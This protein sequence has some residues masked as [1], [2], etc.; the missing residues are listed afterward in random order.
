MRECG[1]SGW[2]YRTDFIR[3]RWRRWKRSLSKWRKG[4]QYGAPRVKMIS[5]V[6]GKEVGRGEITAEY[7]RRQVREAVRYEK[8]ME[9]LRET[10]QRVFVEVGPGSTLIGLGRQCMEGQEETGKAERVWAVS[11]RKNKQEWEQV[12]ESLGKLYERGAEVDWEGFDRGIRT[13]PRGA[14]HLPVPAPALLD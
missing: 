7:W 11:I 14:A 6:T 4:L 2:R 3:R 5:S 12:L 9:T 10:G 13:A 8:A 1:Y